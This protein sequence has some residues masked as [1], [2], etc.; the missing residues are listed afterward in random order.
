VMAADGRHHHHCRI[1]MQ[2][3]PRKANARSFIRTRPFL[4]E[5]S[6]V[7]VHAVTAD[8]YGVPE[9]SFPPRP[10]HPR[11]VPWRT[12]SNELIESYSH[13]HETPA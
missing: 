9:E 13:G 5:N 4:Y 7:W 11:P 1:D 10:R 6:P 3:E 12:G 8:I 2:A